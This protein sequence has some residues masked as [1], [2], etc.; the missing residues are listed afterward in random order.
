LPVAVPWVIVVL[1]VVIAMVSSYYERRRELVIYSTIGMN[2]RHLTGVLLAEAAIIGVTGGCL[3]YLL[4]IG[5][6]KIIFTLTPALQVKQKVSAFWSLAAIGFSLAAALVGGFSAFFNST[7][8]TPSFRRR[9]KVTS[10]RDETRNVYETPLPIR[11]TED[12]RAL[13]GV[14]L[15]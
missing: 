14:H 11:I 3:G 12:E 5:W 10:K 2:P 4:G 1:N 7:A 6:Y 8:I 9:W 15:R 13:Q